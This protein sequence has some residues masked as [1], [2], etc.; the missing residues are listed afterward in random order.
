MANTRSTFFVRSAVLA[1]LCAAFVAQTYHASRATSITFDETHYLGASL[2]T[3]RDH[4][5]D[6]R[7][8][9]VGVAPVPIL[10]T[11]LPALAREEGAERPNLWIGELGDAT[12]I[13]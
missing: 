13:L 8:I 6:S 9:A 2:R 12:K 7:L 4:K 1:A 11:Y 3:I 10:L 5:L